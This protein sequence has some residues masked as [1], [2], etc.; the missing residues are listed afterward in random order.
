MSVLGTYYVIFVLKYACGLP[1]KGSRRYLLGMDIE[2]RL[3]SFGKGL[4]HSRV[5]SLLSESRA[6]VGCVKSILSFTLSAFFR[7]SIFFETLMTWW[8][9]APILNICCSSL[10]C[11]HSWVIL[12]Q[13]T[14]G[15]YKYL[16][17]LKDYISTNL[18]ICRKY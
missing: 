18:V 7:L 10:N 4:Q 6:G 3:C 12:M 8:K 13:T 14:P 17:P 9:W 15:Q 1:E 11:F 5:A 2:K 16:I